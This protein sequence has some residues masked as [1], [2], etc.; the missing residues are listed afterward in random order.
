MDCKYYISDECPHYPHPISPTFHLFSQFPWL[1]ILDSK[2]F[3][4]NLHLYDGWS[5]EFQ[6]QSSTCRTI[7]SLLTES[8]FFCDS[9]ILT[10]PPCGASGAICFCRQLGGIGEGSSRTTDWCVSALWAIPSLWADFWWGNDGS[11]N[12][13]ES[14]TAW[15]G[16][17]NQARAIT[18]ES[19][20]RKFI[21][22]CIKGMTICFLH[23]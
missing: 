4:L 10:V 11:F 3:I 19:Y 15:V 5:K 21:Q 6:I 8:L 20:E 22:I 18:I 7:V 9:C 1:S 16:W 17:L 2:F 23:L 12:T 13:E 14:S